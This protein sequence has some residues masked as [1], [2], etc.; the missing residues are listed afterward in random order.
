M[1]KYIFAVYLVLIAIGTGYSQTDTVFIIKTDTVFVPERQDIMYKLFVE[2]KEPETKHLWKVN[3]MNSRL[4][5]P[6]I[7]YEQRIAKSWSV[8][9]YA[10]Y[11]YEDIFTTSN[12]SFELE[13]S[14]KYYFNLKSR[15][16]RGLK[17]NGFSGD[18]FS[19]SVCYNEKE[20]DDPIRGMDTSYTFSVYYSAAKNLNIGIK[21]GIQ[22]RIGR[23]GYIE[24]YAGWYYNCRWQKKNRDSLR[25]PSSDNVSWIEYSHDIWRRPVVGIKAGFAIGSF[26][27]LKRRIKD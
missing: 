16:R 15:E 23:F 19:T 27:N 12:M 7:G 17:T 18:Y 13:Q 22:R 5:K 8:E 9:G 2:N 20:Y 24:F 10:S 26:D 21:Y 3:L 4:L 1:K 14:F 6:D 25:W 11:G